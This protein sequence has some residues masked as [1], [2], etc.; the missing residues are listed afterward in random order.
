MARALHLFSCLTSAL[1]K[2]LALLLIYFLCV[3]VTG[4]AGR[5]STTSCSDDGST[6][7]TTLDDVTCVKQFRHQVPVTS[8]PSDHVI[9]AP[10]DVQ[11]RSPGSSSDKVGAYV[12]RD[13]MRYDVI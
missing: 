3:R 10:Q 6:A 13:A 11:D 5:K 9:G 1:R 4:R 12:R 7:A 8:S 2:S